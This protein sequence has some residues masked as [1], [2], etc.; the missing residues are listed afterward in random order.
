MRSYLSSKVDKRNQNGLISALG[1]RYEKM[2][3]VAALNPDSRIHFYILF[4]AFNKIETRLAPNSEYFFRLSQPTRGNNA[5][6]NLKTSVYNWAS[7]VI[8]DPSYHTT[9]GHDDIEWHSSPDNHFSYE[10][11][12]ANWKT[13]DTSN[14]VNPKTQSVFMWRFPNCIH[15]SH[16]LN[17]LWL[18]DVA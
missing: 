15:I 5:A 12:V 11:N 7:E 3:G 1:R 13:Q 16:W 9:S 10:R 2:Q 8:L 6:L 17:L 14:A 4:V 18:R